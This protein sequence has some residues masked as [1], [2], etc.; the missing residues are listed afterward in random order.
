MQIFKSK[1]GEIEV[2]FSC[3]LVY[4]EYNNFHKRMLF[5]AGRVLGSE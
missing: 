5:L 1:F 2:L 4:S 3:E